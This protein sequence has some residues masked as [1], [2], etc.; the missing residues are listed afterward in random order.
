MLSVL[1]VE[2]VKFTIEF[3]AKLYIPKS[4]HQITLTYLHLFYWAK[5]HQID[6]RLRKL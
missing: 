2:N 5:T 4:Y 1:E 6:S 3:G